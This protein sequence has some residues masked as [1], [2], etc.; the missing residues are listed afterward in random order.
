MKRYFYK[1]RDKNGKIVKGQVEA[2]NKAEAAKL[3]RNRAYVVINLRSGFGGFSV[4]LTRW[5][6][7]V[8]KGDVT[9][10]TRQFATMI[11]AGL[12]IS[13]S[14]AILRLQSK[15][16]MQPII[17]QI[18]A[19]VEGGSSLSS[20]LSKH[21]RAFSPTYIAL[22]KAGEAG[23][24]LDKVMAR[25]AD[26]MEKEQEFRGKVKGALI[27][28]VII[29]IGMIVVSIIMVVFV[30]PRLTSLYDQFGATLPFM[31]QILLSISNFFQTFWWFILILLFFG[32]WA[33]SIFRK[34]K[35]GR[36]KIAEFEFKIPIFGDLQREIVI[37]ELTRTLALMVGAGVP[38]LEGI[39][40]TSDVVD[41]IIISDAMKAA[42]KLVEKG[43]PISFAFGKFPEAFPYILSQMIAVGEETGKMEEVLEKVS[44]VFEVDSEQKV[45]ALTSAIE[46]II[47]IILGVGVAFLVIAVILPIYNLTSAI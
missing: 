18:L 38:I 1:A 25:L 12:P 14:L 11:N 39:S 19:D 45:K 41:N 29:V 24:V 34:T 42:G 6:T 15:N 20:A 4:I 47:M 36:R 16:N 28:P 35:E 17:T 3:L 33:F 2:A 23:G 9:S 7:R 10:F 43:F 31:T 13:E 37:A 8:T 21:T 30:I 22:V 40:V 32:G 44:H 27:Y 5:R 26:N 46:P